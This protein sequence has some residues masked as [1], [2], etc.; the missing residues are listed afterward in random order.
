MKSRRHVDRTKRRSGRPRKNWNDA[1]HVRRY[2][3]QDFLRWDFF[4]T[5][6]IFMNIRLR[7]CGTPLMRSFW[8]AAAIWSRV[9][10]RFFHSSSGVLSDA[11]SFS[12]SNLF[13]IYNR[14]KSKSESIWNCRISV[15]EYFYR[16]TLCVRVVVAVARCP[17]V[18]PSVTFVYC[19]Q[20]AEDIVKLLSRPSSPIIL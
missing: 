2:K 11:C 16:A 12:G 17:S 18:E 4:Y 13:R 20:T 6:R 15:Y 5:K 8:I 1:I 3:I 14:C 19:I 7:K 9:L 10:F